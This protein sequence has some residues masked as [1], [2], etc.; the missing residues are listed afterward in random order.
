MPVFQKLRRLNPRTALRA[1]GVALTLGLVALAG[2]ASFTASTTSTY[3][4]RAGD[5]LWRIASSHGLTV[6]QLA[7][8]NGLNPNGLLLIGTTL[9][10]PSSGSSS[11]SSSPSSASRGTVTEPALASATTGTSGRSFCANF[12]V[13]GGSEP[14]PASLANDP[15]RLA[16]RP[17]FV[18]WADSYGISPSLLEAVAWQESGWQEGAVS[19]A[20]AV[21]VGQLLPST[22]QYVSQ[23][24][25]GSALSISSASDNIQMSARYL[26]YL[27]NA[28]GSTCAALASYNEGLGNYQ[29][30]GV[31]PGVGGYVQSVADYVPAFS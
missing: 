23:H 31:L 20:N 30:Y 24:L 12:S 22:A 2:Q 29:A 16:L 25:I 13:P 18:Q 28:T 15:S 4:V 5:D 3:T 1:G 6:S 10:I 19:S 11:V 14:L 17:L 26:A 7:A 9:V 8:A 21:G 27:Y